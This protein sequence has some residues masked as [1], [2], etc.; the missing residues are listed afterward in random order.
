MRLLTMPRVRVGFPQRDLFYIDKLEV[1]SGEKIG[2]I[3]AN[4]AGKSTLFRVLT[5]DLDALEG[6]ITTEGEWQ[7]FRQLTTRIRRQARRSGFSLLATRSAVAARTRNTVR[8][9]KKQGAVYPDPQY[10][11]R[12]APFR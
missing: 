6:T 1:F 11:G 2:L 3:G 8:R 9:R 7:L 5:D 12:H 10:T 4:G